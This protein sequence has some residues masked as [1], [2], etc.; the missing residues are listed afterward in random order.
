L[1]SSA[2]VD[3][4]G[5]AKTAA[6]KREA[7]SFIGIGVSGEQNRVILQCGYGFLPFN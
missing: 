6:N 3:K 1:A 5:A 7:K 4:V 2:K